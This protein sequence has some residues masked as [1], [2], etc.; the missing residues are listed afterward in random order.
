MELGGIESPWIKLLNMP[1]WQ[2]RKTGVAKSECKEQ[3][4]KYGN[5][6]EST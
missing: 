1:L 6:K 2:P 5:E 4:V 3:K